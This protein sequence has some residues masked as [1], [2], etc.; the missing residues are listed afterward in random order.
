MSQL[1]RKAR[2]APIQRTA[3]RERI[4]AS[5]A[6]A[7]PTSLASSARSTLDP[8]IP[9]AP[10]GTAA[11]NARPATVRGGRMSK[12]RVGIWRVWWILA[13]K[14]R[15]P[16]R[17]RTRNVWVVISQTWH[18]NG[19][20]ALTLRAKCPCAS[21]HNLHNPHKPQR[22]DANC[23]HANR[24]LH[25]VPSGTARRP[26]QAFPSS[27]SRRQDGVFHLPFTAWLHR[28]GSTRQEY[29]NETCTTC[30]AEF[31]DRFCGNTN[32]SPKTAPPATIPTG[33]RNRLSSRCG[34]RFSARRVTRA[35]AI[36]R[37]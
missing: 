1:R 12:R 31:R 5:L 7:T 14:R 37:S 3:R 19:Q 6:T 28:A 22:S 25:L 32:Q 13:Q 17:N 29:R 35:Q 8:T 9:T 23:S 15:P 18:T 30:H 34:L 4:P 10:L 33:Q 26:R 2:Q 24:R 16:Q 27:T 36:R 11:F 20:P 21:C